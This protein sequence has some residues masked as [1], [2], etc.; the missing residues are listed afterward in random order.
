MSIQ[1]LP[2]HFWKRILYAL[3]FTITAIAAHPAWAVEP[4]SL[5]FSGKTEERQAAYTSLQQSISEKLNSTKGG[6]EKEN[7][8]MRQQILVRLQEL[9]DSPEQLTT[10]LV[11]AELAAKESLTWEEFEQFLNRHIKISLEEKKNSLDLENSQRQIKTLH[12]RLTAL[13]SNDSAI[14]VLQL[15]YAFKKRKHG[16]QQQIDKQL[17]GAL[18]K[19]KKLY[20]LVLEGT[21]IDKQRIAQE[22][23]LHTEQKTQYQ[24]NVDDNALSATGNSIRIQ[25]QENIL[26]D[27]LGKELTDDKKKILFYEESKLIELQVNRLFSLSTRQKHN[28]KQLQQAQKVAWYRLLGESP[29]FS[30]LV[31]LSNDILKQI[32][33]LKKETGRAQ[34]DIYILEKE[35]ALLRNTP[36]S[37]GPKTKKLLT[38]VNSDI[39]TIFA[40]LILIDKEANGL[41]HRG[42]LF[43]MAIDLKQ[44]GIGAVVTK[45]R[46]ATSTVLQQVLF[47]LQ[48]PIISYSGANISLLVLLQVVFIIVLG[49]LAT[50]FYGR[51]ILR[52]GQKHS[53]TEQ[54]SHLLQVGGKYPLFIILAMVVLSVLGINTSSFAMIAGA[55]SVGIGFGLK[56][57][58]NNLVSGIILLFDKSIRPGDFISLG[59]TVNDG[60]LRGNVVEMN[61]RASVLRTNDNINVIIPNATLMESQVVNWTYGDEKVRFRIPFS[62]AYGTDSDHVKQ[63]VREA[64]L[65]TRIVLKRPEPSIQMTAHGDNAVAYNASVWVEGA[66]A[67]RPASTMDTILSNIYKVLNENNLEIPFP[68]MDIHVRNAEGK[69]AKKMC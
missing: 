48:Y 59:D 2:V 5:L 61:I 8:L 50:R 47:V 14:P 54:T 20:P 16:L 21:R 4:D 34:S 65:K 57:I 19:A 10:A 38:S 41:E 12:N 39:R 67:R 37:I 69:M 22:E 40:N 62:V 68:Q 3:F 32:I 17:K 35:L 30:E 1:Y 45:T 60:G 9:P 33:L 49:L 27:Y 44:T 13:N 25:E 55:L 6:Q 46:E 63:V 58:V 11:F 29:D 7:L 66:N 53:W 23:K 52:M 36:D 15:Q 64:M 31:D 18:E 56:T 51:F 42:W 26:Q 28:V 43:G 24:Q